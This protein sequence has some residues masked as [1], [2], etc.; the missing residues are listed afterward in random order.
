M[1]WAASPNRIFMNGIA[2]IAASARFIL[3]DKYL[4]SKA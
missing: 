1:S 4:V 2:K 3:H